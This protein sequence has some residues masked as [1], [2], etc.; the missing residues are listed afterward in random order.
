MGGGLSAISQAAGGAPGIESGGRQANSTI[1]S[2]F[3]PVTQ[4]F[5]PPSF[6]NFPFSSSDH[7]ETRA[8]ASA[9]SRQGQRREPPAGRST[10]GPCPHPGG[11]L[12]QLASTFTSGTRSQPGPSNGALVANQR[13]KCKTPSIAVPSG[14]LPFPGLGACRQPLFLAVLSENP[15]SFRGSVGRMGGTEKLRD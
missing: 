1:S 10:P 4:P 2:A 15:S 7:F 14:M 13:A 3:L 12:L 5:P 6:S 11:V 9:S 8:A